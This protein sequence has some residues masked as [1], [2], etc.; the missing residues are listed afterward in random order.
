MV[1]VQKCM[2]ARML[3]FVHVIKWNV[4][5]QYHTSPMYPSTKDL[6]A[7]SLLEIIKIRNVTK[8]S[9][10]PKKIPLI[11]IGNDILIF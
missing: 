4:L 7:M 11:F 8:S 1:K 10:Q 9:R 5:N 3:H 6:H 2:H